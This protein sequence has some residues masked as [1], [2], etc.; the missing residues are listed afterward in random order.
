[1]G[2]KFN[3]SQLIIFLD[4]KIPFSWSEEWDN[5]GLQV[6]FLGE[7]VHGILISLNPTLKTIEQCVEGGFN[8]LITHHPLLF[9]PI[10]QI[11]DEHWPGSFITGA[12]E[13]RLSVI[14]L[15]TNFD[16][17]PF[18]ISVNLAKELDLPISG[19]V[20]SGGEWGLGVWGDFPYSIPVS[21]I[22]DKISRAFSLPVRVV[23]PDARVK[24]YALCGGSCSSLI[25]EVRKMNIDLF[26]TSDVKY[27]DMIDN[28]LLGL[29]IISVD[30][31]IEKWG[32]MH[33]KELL[34]GWLS[35]KEIDVKVE[36]VDT[37]IL[38]K[39]INF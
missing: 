37:D 5:S 27:H 19:P 13:N 28:F 7:E 22:A 10:K 17:A 31:S 36:V 9:S 24:N 32:F 33:L 6:G 23:D 12:I 30:H 2:K 16:K 4:E 15:H 8:V 3:V 18:G 20:L 26:I 21:E 39:W 35:E 1:M 29:N 34:T 38:I 11:D 14:A 25:S